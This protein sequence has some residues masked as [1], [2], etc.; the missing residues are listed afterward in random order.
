[1]VRTHDWLYVY[2]EAYRPQLFDLRNDPN[3]LVDLGA[4][5][6]YETARR[7]LYDCLFLWMR[8][9]RLRVTVTME[10]IQ[11]FGPER[12]EAAGVFIGHW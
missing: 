7:D 8:Q 6:A 9:R 2:H 5:P 11:K 3:Q 10:Q 12:D 1:M 4:D